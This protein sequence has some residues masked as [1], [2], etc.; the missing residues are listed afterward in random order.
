M[1]YPLRY[2][3]P[4][5]IDMM[6]NAK[7]KSAIIPMAKPYS[8]GASSVRRGSTLVN[9]DNYTMSRRESQNSSTLSVPPCCV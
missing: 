1:K 7:K 6:I 4:E 3:S 5:S 8:F 2:V 9:A